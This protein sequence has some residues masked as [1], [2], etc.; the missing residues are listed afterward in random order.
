M[1]KSTVFIILGA[2]LLFLLLLV[3]G[4]FFL[5]SSLNKEK[6][7]ITASQF[8]TIMQQKGFVVQDAT[9][10]F[11]IMIILPKFI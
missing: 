8:Q 1:K 4:G 5:F 2:V 10:H 3:L 6:D 11:Q 7:P 9:S